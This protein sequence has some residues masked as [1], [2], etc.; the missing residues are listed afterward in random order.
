MVRVTAGSIYLQQG[1]GIGGVAAV[2]VTY[3]QNELY[4]AAT[5]A[6]VLFYNL[7]LS[8]ARVAIIDAGFDAS[9]LDTPADAVTWRST[10]T[11]AFA[12]ELEAIN[13]VLDTLAPSDDVAE[14]RDKQAELQGHVVALNRQ[15]C[16]EAVR[17]EIMRCEAEMDRQVPI[18]RQMMGPKA[19]DWEVRAMVNHGPLGKRLQALLAEMRELAQ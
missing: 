19:E 7:P 11:A 12:S 13:I 14:I 6:G 2:I 4:S 18:M 16:I 17:I 10:L 3:Q 1:E 5:A 9:A 15:L 8:A